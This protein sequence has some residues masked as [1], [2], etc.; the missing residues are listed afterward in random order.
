MYFNM[1]NYVLITGHINTGH[2]I[3]LAQGPW[4]AKP[5]LSNHSKRW[6]DPSHPA[7]DTLRK[8]RN[9]ANLEPR[10]LWTE[11]ETDREADT[12]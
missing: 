7:R 1:K 9:P 3:D 6:H 11:E 12:R 5:A 8:S 4:F 2:G 10:E